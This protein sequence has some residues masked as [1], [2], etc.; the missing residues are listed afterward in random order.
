MLG[1]L[2]MTE[3]VLHG[4]CWVCPSCNG[5]MPDQPTIMEFERQAGLVG[6]REGCKLQQV[7]LEAGEITR[8]RN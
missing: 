3:W 6:H 7:L 1:L 2:K 8:D 4:K 5:K